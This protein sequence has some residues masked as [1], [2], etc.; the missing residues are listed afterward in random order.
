MV[1]YAN[2]ARAGHAISIG[3]DAQLHTLKPPTTCGLRVLVGLGV[4]PSALRAWATQK[5]FALDVLLTDLTL[6]RKLISFLG[7]PSAIALGHTGL[8]PP[9]QIPDAGAS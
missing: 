7:C 4:C 5:S 9:T 1:G 8:K 2:P 3:L 6:L